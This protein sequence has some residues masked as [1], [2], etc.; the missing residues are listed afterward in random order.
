[1][2]PLHSSRS[3]PVKKSWPQPCS[4]WYN[5]R[6]W[7]SD[8]RRDEQT[9]RETDGHISYSNTTASVL[10]H[11]CFHTQK[12]LNFMGP[13][14]YSLPGFCPWTPLE[15]FHPQTWN[16]EYAPELGAT[17]STP[18]FPTL[19]IWCRVFH[20]CY[21]VLRFPL[22]RFPPLQFWWCRV[23]S[24]PGLPSSNYIGQNIKYFLFPFTPLVPARLRAKSAIY[25][26]LVC[27]LKD[28]KAV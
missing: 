18:A 2:Y 12:G 6:V 4:F 3:S 23:F 10:S 11:L 14:S 8:G 1:M 7:R 13:S 28:S 26:C 17:F 20:P 27:I 25:D 5:T 22:P 21:L 24:Q 9:N 15:D 19:V 16:P